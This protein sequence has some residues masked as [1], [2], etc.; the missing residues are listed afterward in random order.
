MAVAAL[1]LTAYVKQWQQREPRTAH[2]LFDQC[3]DVHGDAYIQWL[4]RVVGGWLAPNDGNLRAFDYAVRSMPPEGAMIE[5]GSFVGLSTNI[6]AYLALKHGR[7]NP[8][9]SCDPWIFEG[10]EEPI[11]GYFDAGSPAYRRYAKDVFRLNVE[12][13]SESRKPYAMEASSAQFWELWRLGAARRDVFGREVTLGGPISFAYIDGA[14]TYEASR[15]D[16]LGVDRHL[17]PGGF[18]LFDD[19]DDGGCFPDVTRVAREVAQQPSYEVVFK[20]PH[21]FFRKVGG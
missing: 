2:R 17:L 20:T 19:S 13:F 4:C 6:L 7:D 3:R 1:K 5:I 10:A 21:Y 12:L 16:F 14:H 11:G 8:F 15:S 18:L 9:F